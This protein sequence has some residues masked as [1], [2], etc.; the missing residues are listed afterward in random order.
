M[1]SEAAKRMFHLS[2]I[3]DLYDF[4]D[5][6]V[7]ALTCLPPE[8]DRDGNLLSVEFGEREYGEDELRAMRSADDFPFDIHTGTWQ[9][10]P[11]SWYIFTY[12][13]VELRDQVLRAHAKLICDTIQA[14][15][16]KDRAKLG[17]DVTDEALLSLFALRWYDK[18]ALMNER[19]AWRAEQQKKEP[20]ASPE[21][22]G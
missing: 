18:L 4:A 16:K 11:A 1:P 9:G 19:D 8:R 22:E 21:N 12:T 15:V 20:P 2:D 13:P 3:M 6:A 7:V 10:K 17:D 14:L 5:N